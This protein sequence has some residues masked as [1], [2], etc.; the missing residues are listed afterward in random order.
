M[1]H[2]YYGQPFKVSK[3]SEEAGIALIERL[4]NMIRRGQAGTIEADALRHHMAELVS[5]LKEG[6]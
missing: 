6:K 3:T 5:L 1:A 4:E 2:D